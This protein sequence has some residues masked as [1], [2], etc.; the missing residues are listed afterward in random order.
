MTINDLLNQWRDS[1][2]TAQPQSE[3]LLDEGPINEGLY[4]GA[5]MHVRSGLRAGQ[6]L[7]ETAQPQSEELY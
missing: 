5:G 4:K 7:I 6:D 3:E 1:T 2:E